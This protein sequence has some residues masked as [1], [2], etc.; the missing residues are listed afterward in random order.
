MCSNTSSTSF[1]VFNSS[2]ITVSWCYL[3]LFFDVSALV[4]SL[5]PNR[6]DC[7]VS[8]HV[9]KFFA[10]P[11]DGF[12]LRSKLIVKRRRG[13]L[14]DCGAHDHRSRR[15]QFQEDVRA[16]AA[17]ELSVLVARVLAISPEGIQ[18]YRLTLVNAKYPS[19]RILFA[20]DLI[21]FYV[22]LEYTDDDP[23]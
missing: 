11:I 13:A 15:S 2:S 4:A 6:G 7:F 22:T 20:F 10:S 9:A 16:L 19:A 18:S 1:T 23:N 5:A 17:A 21:L 3:A 12:V 8:K 14:G